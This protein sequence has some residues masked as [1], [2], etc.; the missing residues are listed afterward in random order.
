RDDMI[1]SSNIARAQL[2]AVEI[3][4]TS[5]TPDYALAVREFPIPAEF[6][7][8]AVRQYGS[9]P[10]DSPAELAAQ[11]GA[12]REKADYGVNDSMGI[13][14]KEHGLPGSLSGQCGARSG[15]SP[16]FVR[17]IPEEGLWMQ[18]ERAVQLQVSL[19]RFGSRFTQDLAPAPAGAGALLRPPADNAPDRPWYVR[20][21]SPQGG[22]RVCS[23]EGG[24]ASSA[25][26][27]I[28]IAG[29]SGTASPG[30][31]L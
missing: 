28:G 3:A 23:A 5:I 20:I 22:F 26:G 8:A 15:A 2:G 4:G 18:P 12:L 19:R 1:E 27:G 13:S 10:A 9:S 29:G 11:P 24:T 17:E 16:Q 31:A 6:Y 25:G 7:L 30:G 21:R 14:P